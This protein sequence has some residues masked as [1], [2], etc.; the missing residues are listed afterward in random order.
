[1]GYKDVCGGWRP[2]E[3]LDG[4]QACGVYD[5]SAIDYMALKR[6]LMLSC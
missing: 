6:P 2:A 4:T 1:M 3:A 5:A